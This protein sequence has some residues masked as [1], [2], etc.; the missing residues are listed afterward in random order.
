MILSCFFCS[1][2]RTKKKPIF[3]LAFLAFLLCVAYGSRRCC[4]YFSLDGD[5]FRQIFRIASAQGLADGDGA[6]LQ[7]VVFAE[8]G[9]RLGGGRISD[10][11]MTDMFG[12]AVDPEAEDDD[13]LV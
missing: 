9:E 11:D 7:A 8:D 6:F 12:E 2:P 1:F 3:L 5:S 13:M 4:L 10:K